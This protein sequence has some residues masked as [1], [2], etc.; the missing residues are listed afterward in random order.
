MEKKVT[1]RKT[2]GAKAKAKR[3]VHY[4]QQEIDRA[5]EAVAHTEETMHYTNLRLREAR[6]AYIQA[7]SDYNTENE[8]EARTRARINASRARN[9]EGGNGRGAGSSRRSGSH[10][11]SSS[12]PAI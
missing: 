9:P 4:R 3:S 5:Q 12:R 8:E 6:R 10:S 1:I 11:S 7:E 2:V